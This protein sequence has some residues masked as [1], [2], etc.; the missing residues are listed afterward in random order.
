MHFSYIPLALA[1]L[2]ALS[3]AVP[4]STVPASLSAPS[5]AAP[6]TA[7]TVRL[8]AGIFV[9]ASEGPANKF[10]G[11][12]FAQP[13]VGDLRFRLPVP[14]APYAGTYNASAFGLA[15]AQQN[16]TLRVP[17]AIVSN[18]TQ[19][20][21][22]G[23]IAPSGEDCLTLNVY[24][25]ANV[26]RGAKLPVVVWIFGGGFEFGGTSSYDGT[27]VVATSVKMG[28]PVIFVSMNYRLSLF[29]FLASKEVKEAGVGNLGLQDQRLA[30]H[31]VQEYISAFGGDPAKVTLWGE[32]AGALSVA[33]HMTTNG[34]DAEGLFR[35]AFMQS[36]APLAVGDI[37]GGQ[38]D[39]DRIVADAGCAAARD[40]LQCLREAPFETLLQAANGSPAL[41]GPSALNL[42]WQPRVDGVFVTDVP[43][44]LVK[45]G[46]VADVP[47]VNGN[48]DDEGTL[49]SLATLNITTDAEVKAYLQSNYLP[50][51]SSSQLDKILELYPQDPAQGSPFGT[52]TNNTLSPQFKRLAA[53]QGDLVFQSSRRF[54]LQERA[55]KQPAFAYIHKRF[56]A[57]PGIGSAHITDIISVFGGTDMT[58]YLVNFVVGLNPNGPGLLG[59]PAYSTAAPRLM[60]FLDGPVPLNITADDF[61]V[62][63]MQLLTELQQA[64]PLE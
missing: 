44:T 60:T 14:A 6:P 52:G 35:G 30:L 5:A 12:P 31:W 26:T 11:I 45:Q 63:G 22:G 18:V 46:S 24:T 56:K 62:E 20:L 4:T 40:T 59:W 2:A 49:F 17:P 61:R 7:P 42:S 21:G 41:F 28:T 51:A 33:L 48:C 50:E 29:G 1:E 10:L 27:A 54:F 38:A 53:I 8:D 15:C 58:E 55:H 13:P 16:D 64:H 25:P 32:S 43:Q 23:V 57:T 34:G 19:F 37:S 39:Y 9:G 47:F 3:R 36:G